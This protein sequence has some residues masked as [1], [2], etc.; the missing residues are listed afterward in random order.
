VRIERADGTLVIISDEAIT[1]YE[2]EEHFNN[3]EAANFILLH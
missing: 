3:S 1:E 2:S